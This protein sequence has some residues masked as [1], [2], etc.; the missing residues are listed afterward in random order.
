[1]PQCPGQDQRFWKPEDIFEITCPSCAK[2]VEF[3]RD[4]PRRCCPHCKSMILNPKL[5]KGCAE[6]CKHAAECL[7]DEN[8]A[9]S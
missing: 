8:Q 7:G 1:M 4:D 9:G 6:W 5:A 3:W 2:K